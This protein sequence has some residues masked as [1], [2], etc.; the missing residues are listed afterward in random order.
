[1]AA[2]PPDAYVSPVAADPVMQVLRGVPLFSACREEELRQIGRHS[3]RVDFGIGDVV[4]REG[5]LGREFFVIVEGEVRVL[6]G[7]REVAVLHAG[8]WFGELAL[9]DPA[10]RNATVIALTPL[11]TVLLG[12]REF[13]GLLL[14]L[15]GVAARLLKGMARRMREL[16][17]EAEGDPRRALEDG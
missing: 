16:E 14:E 10:P 12:S 6:V 2:T 4:V 11:R 3:E 15:P 5:E 9:L 1:M 13:G 17:R 8:D 7:S